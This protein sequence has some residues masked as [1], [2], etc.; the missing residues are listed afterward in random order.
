MKACLGGRMEVCLGGRMEAC[1]GGRL[2]ACLGGRLRGRTLPDIGGGGEGRG[3]G[4]TSSTKDR[5]TLLL[6]FT[7]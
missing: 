2:E 6:L 5:I 4:L 1:L 7:L 3:G